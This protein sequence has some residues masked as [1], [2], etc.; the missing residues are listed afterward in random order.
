M[1]LSR[2]K[3]QAMYQSG[4]KHYDYTV[5]LYRLIGLPMET[6]RSRAVKLLRLQRGD[7][8]VELGCGTGLN[9]PRLIEQI[10]PQG[11]LIGVDMTPE[12]LVRAR[13]KVERS[14]WNN[15]ELVQSDIAVYEFP[16]A[17]NGVLSTGVFGY[18]AESDR[19]IEA[20]SHA[21]AP[22]GRL[23]IVDGKQP[24]RLPSWL[25]KV[26]LWLARP[27]GVTRD[28]FDRHT[29]ESVERHFQKSTFEQMY[30][31]M[32]YISSGTAP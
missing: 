22:G 25:F 12:M 30:G 29:W 9:F 26:V 14:G 5:Q 8:V 31:G 23:A 15:V 3:V 4:A 10:G 16:E 11:R 1:A 6:C 19:L 18:I 27:F 17:V 21:L 28:Y 2:Q 24:E 7:T 20:V 32:L 13:E